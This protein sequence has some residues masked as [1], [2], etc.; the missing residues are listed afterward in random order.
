[1]AYIKRNGKV[2]EQ[3]INEVEVDVNA[4][5][6]KLQAWKDAIS[7]DAREFQEYQDKIAEIDALNIPVEFKDKL[8]QS[9]TFYSGSGIT[10]ARV[11]EQES[12][13]TAIN[14]VVGIIDAEI[15]P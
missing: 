3:T 9:V 2:Y 4:E 5:A 6:Y 13:V 8:K 11:D 12:K 10:Q 14:D 7:S 15:K 1:M